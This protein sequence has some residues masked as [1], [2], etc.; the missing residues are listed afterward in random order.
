[1]SFE[2]ETTEAHERRIVRC[3]SCQARIIFL[4]TSLGKLMPVD[5][6]TVD[7]GDEEFDRRKHESHFAKCSSADDHRKKVEHVRN[8]K[9]TRGHTCHWPGCKKQVPPAMWGCKPH[10]FRLPKELRDRIWKT[11]RPGQEES[12]TPSTAYIEAAEAVQAW[13]REHSA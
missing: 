11:Y 10:W 12:L 13:I 1:M 5:A 9:Q 8:A 2:E 6:D 7:P 3:R 4:K